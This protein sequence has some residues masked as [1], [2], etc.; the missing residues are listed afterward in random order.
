[1]CCCSAAKW[2]SVQELEN[3]GGWAPSG[4]HLQGTGMEMGAVALLQTGGRETSPL[5]PCP[6]SQLH[7]AEEPRRFSAGTLS[8]LNVIPLLALLHGWEA[9]LGLLL[10]FSPN[11]SCQSVDCT[12]TSRLKSP[13]PV[14]AQLQDNEAFGVC[15][16][17]DSLFNAYNT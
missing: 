14:L 16:C 10:V 6:G 3:R 15:I 7:A 1:M 12:V 2:L 5:L 17:L 13:V 8:F 9:F 4:G 11:S